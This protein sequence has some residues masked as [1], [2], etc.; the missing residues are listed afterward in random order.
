M[1]DGE[2]SPMS[3]GRARFRGEIGL[4]RAAHPYAVGFQRSILDSTGMNSAWAANPGN[5]GDP[6][7]DMGFQTSPV[8]A[9]FCWNI[10]RWNP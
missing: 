2:F 9:V 4:T 10:N 6:R 5:D 7:R 8:M 3:L 1:G